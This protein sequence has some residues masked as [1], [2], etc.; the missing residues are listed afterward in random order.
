VADAEGERELTCV[1]FNT[2]TDLALHLLE[3]GERRRNATDPALRQRADAA[4]DGGSGRRR[5]LHR[6]VRA[7]RLGSVSPSA[8]LLLTA[9]SS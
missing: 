6:R 3:G 2:I 1:A 4:G 7:A 9:Q 8:W 5:C